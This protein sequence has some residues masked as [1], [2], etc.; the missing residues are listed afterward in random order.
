MPPLTIFHKYFM[1]VTPTSILLSLYISY[2]Y[3]EYHDTNVQ[4]YQIA[5]IY[6]IPTIK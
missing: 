6:H 2:I 4:A 3:K 5:S 1:P